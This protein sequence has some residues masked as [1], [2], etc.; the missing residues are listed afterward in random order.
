MS[1]VSF[2]VSPKDAT[3]IQKIVDRGLH[4]AK[5][6]GRKDIN[7]MDA[8]MDITAVHANGNPLKL[9]EFLFADD[10]NFSHDFFGINRRIDR[11][12]G[13]LTDCFSPRFSA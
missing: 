12:T 9:D 1:E 13:G 6:A 3:L 10:F 5:A 11:S 7:R 2:A 4:A 8:E